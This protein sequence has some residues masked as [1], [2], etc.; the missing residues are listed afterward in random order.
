MM[1][2]AGTRDQWPSSEFTYLFI[3]CILVDKG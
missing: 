3:Y 2:M 1:M